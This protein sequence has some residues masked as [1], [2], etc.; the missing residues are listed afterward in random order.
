MKR[1]VAFFSALLLAIA[2]AFSTIQPAQAQYQ[3]PDVLAPWMGVVE[4]CV[5][6]QNNQPRCAIGRS[7]DYYDTREACEADMRRI[8]DEMYRQEPE[9]FGRFVC[10]QDRSVEA[11]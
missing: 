5:L 9:L 11:A 10:V 3:V 8:T 2:W 7:I 6:D 4:I 1:Y